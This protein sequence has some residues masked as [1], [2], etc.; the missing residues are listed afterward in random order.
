V[1]LLVKIEIEWSEVYTTDLDVGR[2]ENIQFSLLWSLKYNEFRSV[3]YTSE[4]K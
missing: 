1:T 4:H 3:C 2:K